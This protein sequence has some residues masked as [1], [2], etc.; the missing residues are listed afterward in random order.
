M[1]VYIMYNVR[2][3]SIRKWDQMSIPTRGELIFSNCLSIVGYRLNCGLP[4]QLWVSVSIVVFRLNCGFPSQL[5]FSVSIVGYRLN[6][7]LPSGG[8]F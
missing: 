3:G 6:C 7:G 8:I 1:H 2:M 4:S 5:W